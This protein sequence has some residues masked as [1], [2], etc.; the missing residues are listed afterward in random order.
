MILVAVIL[1]LAVAV[2]SSAQVVS[3]GLSLISVSHYFDFVVIQ[4]AASINR[5]GLHIP[6]Y[7]TP[8]YSYISYPF[9][10]IFNLGVVIMLFT[11][12]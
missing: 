1:L 4:S 2:I 9:F 12:S 8:F 6:P 7:Y 3:K 5:R 11:S 10:H